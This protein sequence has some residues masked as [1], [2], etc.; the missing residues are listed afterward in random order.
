MNPKMHSILELKQYLK[1]GTIKQN[2]YDW[3]LRQIRNGYKISWLDLSMAHLSFKKEGKWLEMEDI[4]KAFTSIDL[5]FDDAVKATY[6]KCNE[7]PCPDFS[8]KVM[9]WSGKEE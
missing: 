1:D 6:K 5:H 2:T 8:K 9:G 3:C 7:M 4:H